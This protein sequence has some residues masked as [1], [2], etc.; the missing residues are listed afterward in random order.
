MK[1][2]ENRHFVFSE[3]VHGKTAKLKQSAQPTVFSI[4]PGE[5]THFGKHGTFGFLRVAQPE[6]C[7]P[8]WCFQR[9]HTGADDR[10]GRTT[11]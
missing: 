5:K 11:A 6:N 9:F 2:I 1:T 8:L 7:Q 3:L 10:Q 4:E